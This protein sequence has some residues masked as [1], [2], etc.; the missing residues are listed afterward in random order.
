[1]PLHL[2]SHCRPRA[3]TSIS[4]NSS[5]PPKETTLLKI[6][7]RELE[8]SNRELTAARLDV[9]PDFAIGPFFSR[10]V[11]GDT[12]QNVG[13]MISAQFPSGTGTSEAFRA[14]RLG[15]TLP[16]ACASR[17]NAKSKRRS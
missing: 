1:M 5:S 15:A 6:R 8:R 2:A 14:P 16:K 12:E 17:A 13:A 7:Q 3:I 4:V 10:D 9:A 11:A